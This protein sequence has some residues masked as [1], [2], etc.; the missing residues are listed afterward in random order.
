[1]ELVEKINCNKWKSLCD[2]TFDA[3]DY[4]APTYCCVVYVPMDQIDKFFSYAEEVDGEDSPLNFI[5]V[6]ANSDY[7]I[8]YQREHPIWFDMKKWL[9]FIPIDNS[10]GY[11]PLISPARCNLAECK[12]SDKYSIKMHSFT[13]ATFKRIPRCITH[14]FC[15]NCDIEDSRVT[16]IPFGIPDWS[17]KLIN[18]VEEENR[19][20]GFYL[21][22]QNNTAERTHLKPRFR[23]VENFKVIDEEISHED[24][25]NNL[26]KSIYVPCPSGNGLD[27]YRV[28]ETIYCGAVPILPTSRWTKAYKNLPVITINNFAWLPKIAEDNGYQVFDSDL[29]N[30]PAD[31]NYWRAMVDA[32][33]KKL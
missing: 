16:P 24:Y 27:T 13:K 22:F 8:S 17:E 5:V 1:M 29:E 32:A 21:N 10:L 4:N 25:I 26:Y 30:S 14:W 28:L 6:S 31:F 2:W 15:T 33:K 11:N 12:E 23:N 9:D 20:I 19:N 18:K 3:P 7:G